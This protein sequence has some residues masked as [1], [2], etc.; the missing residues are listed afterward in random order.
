MEIVR[1]DEG[2]VRVSGELHISDAEALRAGLLGELVASSA[3][4]L[5]LSGV[6]SCDTASFQLLC[7]LRKSAEREGKALHLSAPAAAMREASATIG[8]SLEDLTNVPNS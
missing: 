3:L 8:L 7:A 5:E 4:V 1:Q 2:L 6:E